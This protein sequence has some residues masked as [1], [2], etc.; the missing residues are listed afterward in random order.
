VELT[1]EDFKE[2]AKDPKLSKWEKIGFPDEY[3]KNK[4][5]AIYEDIKSKLQLNENIRLLDIGCGC[6]GLVEHI[7]EDAVKNLSRSKHVQALHQIS[8]LN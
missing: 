7:I 6:G 8:S 4:E 2:R 1:F 5:S 3:R